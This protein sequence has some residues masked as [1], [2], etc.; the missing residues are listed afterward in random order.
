MPHTTSPLHRPHDFGI[1]C[2]LLQPFPWD[3]NQ[4]THTPLSSP[5]ITPPTFTPNFFRPLYPSHFHPPQHRSSAS[6][7]LAPHAATSSPVPHVWALGFLAASHLAAPTF[8]SPF[9][10]IPSLLAH[11]PLLPHPP[12]RP[13]TSTP[14]AAS[15][16]KPCLPP[17]LARIRS[18]LHPILT[19]R[20]AALTTL[21]PVLPD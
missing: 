7:F 4:K 11:L 8:W 5:S 6:R 2:V 18:P 3:T 20:T 15:S 10:P 9:L 21:F 13:Q 1:L 16:L 12:P 14:C 19:R 17:T